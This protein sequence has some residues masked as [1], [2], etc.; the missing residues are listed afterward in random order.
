MEPLLDGAFAWGQ[1]YR[2][3]LEQVCR[4]PAQKKKKSSQERKA[5]PGSIERG[6]SG[7]VTAGGGLSEAGAAGGSLPEAVI[8]GGG[9]SEAGATEKKLVKELVITEDFEQNGI[10]NWPIRTARHLLHDT[11]KW[12]AKDEEFCKKSVGV[13]EELYIR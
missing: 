10:K 7:A 1:P 3:N 6:L 8:A 9:L 4:L 2:E 12:A 11:E 13:A 5:E